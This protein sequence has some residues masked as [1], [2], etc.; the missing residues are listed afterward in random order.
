MGKINFQEDFWSPKYH[1][2]C[3]QLHKCH[4]GKCSNLQIIA[5]HQQSPS[6]ASSEHRQ[7]QLDSALVSANSSRGGCV[8]SN[9]PIQSDTGSVFQ[10]RGGAYVRRS[11]ELAHGLLYLLYN[12][13]FSIIAEVQL[14][15]RQKSRWA[16]VTKI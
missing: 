13:L 4:T 7:V 16:S 12:G 14:H 8:H 9:H 5:N 3:A 10:N 2:V 15:L 11:Y 1:L 6:W